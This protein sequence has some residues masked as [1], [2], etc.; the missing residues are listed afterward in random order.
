MGTCEYMHGVECPVC[1]LP[2]LYP[3]DMNAYSD[4]ATAAERNA[5]PA[6]NNAHIDACTARLE[7]DLAMEASLDIECGI[8]LECPAQVPAAGV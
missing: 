3:D 7:R 5:Y 4:A 1:G 6:H 8:C 2:V